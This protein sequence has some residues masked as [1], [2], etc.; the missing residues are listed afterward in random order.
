M[1]GTARLAAKV[2]AGALVAAGTG[3]GLAYAATSASNVSPRYAY[4]SEQ[5]TQSGDYQMANQEAYAWMTG[6]RTAPGWERGSDLPSFMMGWTAEH[7]GA[8]VGRLFADA[9]GPRVSSAEAAKVA[10]VVPPGATV[11]AARDR[12]SFIGQHVRLAAVASPSMPAERFRIA[13]LTDPAIVVPVGATVHVTVINADT[14]M[15]HGLV[16]TRKGASPSWMSL[17]DSSPAFFGS[18]LWFLADAGA[19]G[20]HEGALSFTASA[21]GTY[22]YLCPVPGHAQEG[23]VGTFVVE[24]TP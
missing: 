12:I 3:V 6:G 1:T 10:A 17:M 19:S 9:P 11:D 13:G 18:A 22:Q 23:M 15:A 21:A 16:V 2:T 20:M 14:N 24:G 5:V 8:Y 4:Y 7:P